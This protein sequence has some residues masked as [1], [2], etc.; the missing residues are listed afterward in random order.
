MKKSCDVNDLLL[1]EKSQ[2]QQPRSETDST[3]MMIIY[4]DKTSSFTTVGVLLLQMH[5]T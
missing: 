3:R 5:F 4:A 1:A 2:Y